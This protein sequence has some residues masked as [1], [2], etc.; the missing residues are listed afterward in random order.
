MA[1]HVPT[2]VPTDVIPT[3]PETTPLNPVEDGGTQ[4][5]RRVNIRVFI[6]VIG[7]H[8]FA[9]FAILLYSLGHHT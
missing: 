3:N 6:Y 5:E 8:L 2:H 4:T 7:F 9:G 1:D